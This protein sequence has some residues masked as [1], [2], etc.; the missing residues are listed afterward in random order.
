MTV[1]E[2]HRFS[3]QPGGKGAAESDFALC[4]GKRRLDGGEQRRQFGIAPGAMGAER[5]AVAAMLQ[6]IAIAGL[7]A[8][9]FP[10]PAFVGAFAGAFAGDGRQRKNWR[11]ASY[12][13]HPRLMR[14]AHRGEGGRYSNRAKFPAP[15]LPGRRFNLEYAAR[16]LHSGRILPAGIALIGADAGFSAISRA[17][18]TEIISAMRG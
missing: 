16:I 4:L 11:P 8:A 10:P 6:A 17:A 9:A 13:H 5:R 1:R 15:S 18:L 2:G 12:G 3:P 7:A 14:L